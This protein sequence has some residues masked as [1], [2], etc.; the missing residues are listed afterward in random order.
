MLGWNLG[1]A[2]PLLDILGRNVEFFTAR[3]S[4]RGDLVA[5][6]LLLT[7]GVPVIL[8]AVVAT[9]T[10]F[11]RGAGALA[12]ILV[13]GA[14]LT[15]LALQVAL[16][17]A[18]ESWPGPFLIAVCAV[19][20]LAVAIALQRVAA[21]RDVARL[22]LAVP[23]A[24]IGM[25]AFAS[26]AG[27]LLIPDDVASSDIVVGRPAPVV[28]AI[29]DELPLATLLDS[30]RAIDRDLFP[31]FA[32]LADDATWYRNTTT[33]ANFSS[34]AVPAILDG[35]YPRPGSEPVTS[36]HPDNLLQLLGAAGYDVV[37]REPITQLCGPPA[38][39]RGDAAESTGARW[40]T[41]ASDGTMVWLH[42]TLPPGMRGQL[43]PVTLT[44]ADFND[45]DDGDEPTAAAAGPRGL[46]ASIRSRPEPTFYFLH[47]TIPHSPWKYLP[48]GQRYSFDNPAPGM[49]GRGK[50][51][52]RW[53]GDPWLVSLS[54]QRHV[55]QTQFADHLLGELLD[56]LD[57]EGIYDDTLVVVTSDHGISFVPD[58]AR[59]GVTGAARGA[60]AWVPLFIKEPRQ[61]ESTI[62]DDPVGTIDILPTVLELLEA[63][64]AP[65]SDGVVAGSRSGE[66]HLYD[67]SEGG[68]GNGGKWTPAPGS[69]G[70][71]LPESH[72]ELWAT[73]RRKFA[74]LGRA[75]T[76]VD[77]E[78]VAPAHRDLV[79]VDT[80]QVPIED[81]VGTFELVYPE[82]YDDVDPAGEMV[83]ALARGEILLDEALAS[84]VSLAVAVNGRIAAITRTFDE[85]GRSAQFNAM[86]LPKYFVEGRNTVEVFVVEGAG[87]ESVLRPLSGP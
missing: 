71:E 79:G 5:L 21:L 66:R 27:E 22:G 33:V 78:R 50:R 81:P 56:R 25:F 36:D 42:M 64:G 75:G 43:S 80:A 44:W 47:A 37:A 35:N 82:Y 67:V 60:V 84:H 28:L 14:T 17:T 76:S 34:E 59:R 69:D 65:T 68:S 46:I 53:G 77:L 3:G 55:L 15:A 18:A 49:I 41:L 12:E 38:C 83:P 48:T 11:A 13:V 24:V 6:V 86:V 29:F 23:L 52:K 32:R 57:S 7:L 72:D 26:S 19:V 10:R 63:R 85:R 30:E 4:P 62:V 87:V 1:V 54:Y 40:R 70:E 73:L 8:I 58:G 61:A 31:N 51:T 2:F 74:M 16:R 45:R 9:I 39:V 20:G